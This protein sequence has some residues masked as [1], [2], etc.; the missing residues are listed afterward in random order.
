MLASKSPTE[1]RHHSAAPLARQPVPEVLVAKLL[2]DLTHPDEDIRES[3]ATRLT[4]FGES[5]V[6]QLVHAV[7][8]Q[9]DQVRWR[10]LPVLGAIGSKQALSGVLMCLYSENTAISSAAAQILGRSGDRTYVEPLLELLARRASSGSAVWVIGALGDTGD[11]RAVAPIIDILHYTDSPSVRYTA[12]EALGK[13]GEKRA[14]SHIIRYLDDP[15][16]H[17]REKTHI[18]VEALTRRNP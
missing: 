11:R 10:V 5:V 3:A 1:Q 16:H 15:S 4:A 8:T 17:V 14:L 9:N 13:L 18:A 7:R 6:D 12:I 2:S